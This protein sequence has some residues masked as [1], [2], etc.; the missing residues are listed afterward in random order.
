MKPAKK[1]TLPADDDGIDLFHPA[2]QKGGDRNV[3]SLLKPKTIEAFHEARQTVAR[4]SSSRVAHPGDDVRVT[5][6]G[7]SSAMPSKYR[8]G[9]PTFSRAINV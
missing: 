7:T 5:P 6:L 4:E 2:I 1:P 9:E 3:S 8:N